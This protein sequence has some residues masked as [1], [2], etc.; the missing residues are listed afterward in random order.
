MHPKM[1]KKIRFSVHSQCAWLGEIKVQHVLPNKFTR[2]VGPFVFLQHII[3]YRQSLNESH[4]GPGSNRPHPCR[5]IA[6]L[7]YILAGEV[8]HLDSAGNHVKL[9]SGGVHWMMSGKGIVHD[10]LVRSDLWPTNPDVSV[11]RFWINLP[12]NRKDGEPDYL[13]LRHNEIPEQE[14]GGDTGWIR[15]ISGEY[16][17]TIAKIPCYSKEFLYHVHLEAGRQF[18]TMTEMRF[19]YAAFLPAN[20]AVVNGKGFQAGEFIAFTSP[21]EIIEIKNKSK[22]AIDIIL[23]GGE[24]YNEPIVS[25]GFFVMNTPHEI[26]QA[27]NDYY[28][29]KYGQIK[30]QQVSINLKTTIMETRQALTRTKWGLDP[31][32][33]QIGFKVKYLMVTNVRGVF[34]DYTGSMYTTDDNFSGAEIDLLI[35]TASISTGDGTRDTH[36]KS[37]DFFDVEN[38]RE[39]NFKGTTLERTNEREYVLHGNLSIKAVTKRIQ[40]NVEFNG[41]VKDPWGGKRAAFEIIGKINRKDF[42]LTWNAALETGGIMVGD[43]VAITCEIQLV[44]QPES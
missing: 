33:S 42:G 41:I 29:G 24:P 15:T 32:H 27:Y 8:E 39:I 30:T 31:S 13:S 26:T 18:S 35:D 22:T 10:E 28:D 38:F 21:G 36:L 19:E 3:S 23:F 44:Q 37:P 34:N 14:L 16:G 2:A 12:S 25:D 5:G 9:G 7:T 4:N 11:A 17:N 20:K 1:K 6:T 40:L 43:E